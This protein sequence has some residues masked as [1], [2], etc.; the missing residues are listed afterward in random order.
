MAY[1]C[2]ASIMMAWDCWISWVVF[3]ALSD[4]ADRKLSAVISSSLVIL[5][6]SVT[7]YWVTLLTP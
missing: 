7:V 4:M 5:R 6:V 1:S 2:N 3:C